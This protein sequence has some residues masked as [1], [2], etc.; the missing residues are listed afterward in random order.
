MDSVKI[1]FLLLMLLLGCKNI[2][3]N[4]GHC[5]CHSQFTGS[6]CENCK[7]GYYGDNCTIPCTNGCID[8]T[9]NR[10]GT[11][12]CSPNFTGARCETCFA[13]QYGKTCDKQCGLGCTG[14]ICNKDNGTCICENN[15]KVDEKANKVSTAAVAGG[16]AGILKNNDE[17]VPHDPCV[18]MVNPNYKFP[19]KKEIKTQTQE[20][21]SG[22]KRKLP[23]R[24]PAKSVTSAMLE[25]DANDACG[26]DFV[27]TVDD[28]EGAYYNDANDIYTDKVPVESL[29]RCVYGKT[30]REFEEEFQNVGLY[31]PADN[32]ELVIGDITVRSHKVE[33]KDYYQKRTLTITHV[34]ANGRRRKQEW[35][36]LCGITPST[37]SCCEPGSE[38]SECCEKSKNKE[39]AC[40]SEQGTVLLLPRVRAWIYQHT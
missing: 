34:T 32:Q 31:Y 37:E 39:E 8:G 21:Q 12:D 1:Q 20:K 11:C 17:T 23:G 6:N 26:R 19:P 24:Q 5:S 30:D 16:V 10:N 13:G 36:I 15:Y 29:A 27:N 4:E 35:S 25:I 3:S 28:N 22:E 7:P 33:G 18:Q 38:R 9:C 2:C 14:N 40:Y